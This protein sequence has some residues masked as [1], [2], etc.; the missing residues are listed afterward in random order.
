MRLIWSALW[1]AFPREIHLISE[2]L[3]PSLR[4]P[5][6]APFAAPQE[7][8]RVE[9][10]GQAQAKGEGHGWEAPSLPPAPHGSAAFPNRSRSGAGVSGLWVRVLPE[11]GRQLCLCLSSP[12]LKALGQG[13]G[14]RKRSGRM[15]KRAGTRGGSGQGLHEHFTSC[16]ISPETRLVARSAGRAWLGLGCLCMCPLGVRGRKSTGTL[17]LPHLHPAEQALDSVRV[18]PAAAQQPESRQGQGQPESLAGKG[19][20]KAKE[21]DPQ[22]RF[23]G[24]IRCTEAANEANP[25]MGIRATPQ[26]FICL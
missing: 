19:E 24:Q 23:I 17:L 1:G 13:T 18:R 11:A 8:E 6:L 3:I 26:K 21:R 25:E 20:E 10:G 4:G 12:G 22:G 2:F 9:G 16:T 14:N 5:A 7:V 15:E